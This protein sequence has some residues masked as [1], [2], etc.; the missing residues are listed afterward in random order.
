MVK[1]QLE[2]ICTALELHNWLDPQV[3]Q[4]GQ[5][6]ERRKLYNVVPQARARTL[7]TLANTC[8]ARKI[9]LGYLQRR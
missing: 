6:N 3:V 7:Y 5:F 1:Q 9:L 2:V 8:R 4:A